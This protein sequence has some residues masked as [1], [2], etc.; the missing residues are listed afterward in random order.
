MQIHLYINEFTAFENSVSSVV[1]HAS[2]G[3]LRSGAKGT[4]PVRIWN[5]TLS[6]LVIY[7]EV[8]LNK[9]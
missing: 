4:M 7:F 8:R 5:L 3:L 2:H 6:Q 1:F 9:W